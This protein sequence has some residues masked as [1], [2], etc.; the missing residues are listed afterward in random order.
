MPTYKRRASPAILAILFLV[1]C[2]PQPLPV[3]P[4]PI[5][6][7][8]PAT[9]P[10]E[11]GEAS[12]EQPSTGE[13]EQAEGAS[14]AVDRVEEGRRIVQETGCLSC[15]SVDGTN[16]VGPTF[17]ALFGSETTFEDGTTATADESYIR[18]SILKPGD[19]IVQ[20]YA[21]VMPS[22]YEQQL[23]DDQIDA[24]VAFIESLK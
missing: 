23:S 19:Q 16:L 13:Q 6:T 3:A 5:P 22:T 15:H 18:A 8:P 17:Q 14:A 2:N 21:N 10:S 7:L 12:T 1:A 4:T 24:I 11:G 20:G 9:L